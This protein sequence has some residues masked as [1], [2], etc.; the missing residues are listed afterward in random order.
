MSPLIYRPFSFV[1]LTPGILVTYSSLRWLL[2]VFGNRKGLAKGKRQ[3]E[4]KRSLRYVVI[5]YS[6]L[7]GEPGKKRLTKLEILRGSYWMRRYQ[8]E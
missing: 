5:I 2:G 4:L 1:G 7:F 3:V 6:S 8:T